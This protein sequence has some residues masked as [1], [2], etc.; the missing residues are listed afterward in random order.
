MVPTVTLRDL[1][2]AVSEFAHSEAEV[3]ATV[4]H[5]VNSGLV[6]LRGNFAGANIDL[7]LSKKAIGSSNATV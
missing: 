2:A 6:R 1:V 7:G 5:M 3:V 4:A